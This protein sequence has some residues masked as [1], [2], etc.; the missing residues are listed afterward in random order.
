ME[1][2]FVEATQS[3]V[4]VANKGAKIMLVKRGDQ[5]T[6]DH[7]LSMSQVDSLEYA[8][9]KLIQDHLRQ[10]IRQPDKLGALQLD[11]LGHKPKQAFT[12]DLLQHWG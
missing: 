8:V 3:K 1:L 10:V 12:K 4:R 5:A 7:V 11:T 9:L 2:A 6:G